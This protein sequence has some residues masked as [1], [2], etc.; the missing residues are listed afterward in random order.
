MKYDEI[1][2]NKELKNSIS[3]M[4]KSMDLNRTMDIR[5]IPTNKIQ[6]FKV[7]T[8]KYYPYGES[9]FD[10]CQFT[11][12]LLVALETALTIQ[13]I[14]RSTEKRKISVEIGLP[15]DA[16][17]AI[18]NLKEEFSKRK[19]SI[20][21]FGSV[22]TIPSCISTMEDIYIP[23]RDGKPFVDVDTMTGGNVDIR[24]KVDELKYLRDQLV[25]SLDVPP[26]FLNIE[27]NVNAKST[28][29]EENILFARAIIDYQ[30]DF[31]ANIND[32]VLK[33][34]DIIDPEQ[35]LTIMDNI[36][37]QFPTPKSLHFEMMSRH[38]NEIVNLV[39][40]LERLGVPK[41]YSKRKYLPSIDWNDVDNY[42]IESKIDELSNK[43]DENEE[44]GMGG[45]GTQQF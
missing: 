1:K 19:I 27:E 41:E 36:K 35:A 16:K 15:R 44:P 2:D 20:D 3:I 13:R 30:K 28:L 17:K 31:S 32:L 29:S 45:L 24:S 39:E 40:N 8:T 14:S 22:D 25:A 26:P 4:L 18:E 9:I 5:F 6:H 34:L 7:P 23:M 38:M 33:I 12:K 37:V 10:S 42:Q 21:S 11:A 43:K